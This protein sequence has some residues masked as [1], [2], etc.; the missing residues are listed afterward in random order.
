MFWKKKKKER[1]ETANTS[2]LKAFSVHVEF[3]FRQ[4]NITSKREILPQLSIPAPVSHQFPRCSWMPMQDIILIRM[5]FAHYNFRGFLSQVSPQ[6]STSDHYLLASPLTL[7]ANNLATSWSG[8]YLYST[9][10]ATFPTPNS[11][12]LFHNQ[13]LKFAT[14]LSDLRNSLHA[15]NL[16]VFWRSSHRIHII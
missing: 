8:V 16:S 3:I 7:R 2:F 10:T 15:E 4:K 11:E 6:C 1:R 9:V 5:S 14:S 12:Q 13:H